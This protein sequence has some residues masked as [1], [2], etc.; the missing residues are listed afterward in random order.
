MEFVHFNVDPCHIHVVIH[1]TCIN[2]NVDFA[3]FGGKQCFVT[4]VNG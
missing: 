2:F 1:I 4:G 3:S